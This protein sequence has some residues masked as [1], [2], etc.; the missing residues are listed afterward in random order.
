LS[1]NNKIFSENYFDSKSTGDP[2]INEFKRDFVGKLP[3]PPS[4][5]RKLRVISFEF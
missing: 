5:K 3:I 4:K 2:D 1:R